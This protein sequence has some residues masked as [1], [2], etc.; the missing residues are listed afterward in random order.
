MISTS[1]HRSPSSVESNAFMDQVV[2]SGRASG[3]SVVRL[4]HGIRTIPAAW[5]AAKTESFVPGK[6]TE[7]GSFGSPA[8]LLRQMDI[9]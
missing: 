9:A 7:V 4:W 2:T 1:I 5:P 6:A 8:E 3:S